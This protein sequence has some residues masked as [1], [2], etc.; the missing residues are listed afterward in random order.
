MLWKTLE[1]SHP[2]SVQNSQWRCIRIIEKIF[3]VTYKMW[4]HKICF[5]TSFLVL[6]PH[7]LLLS[8]SLPS[9]HTG[10]LTVLWTLQISFHLGSFAFAA[11][12]LKNTL[13]LHASQSVY[14]SGPWSSCLNP[15]KFRSWLF[16]FLV[17]VGI[18]SHPL[19]KLNLS[20]TL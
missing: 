15:L 2:S 10:L 11:T 1:R 12:S 19:K 18:L 8:P 6:Q 20:N 16:V 17:Y 5:L 7:F 9:R 4:P 13:L 3:P 14:L